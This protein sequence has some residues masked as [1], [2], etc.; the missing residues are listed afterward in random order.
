MNSKKKPIRK[1]NQKILKK[2]QKL[3]EGASALGASRESPQ[4]DDYY[5]D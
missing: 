1:Q 3:F 4:I 2:E 5:Y